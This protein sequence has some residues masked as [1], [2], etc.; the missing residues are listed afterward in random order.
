[1]VWN[2]NS[3]AQLGINIAQDTPG[4][5]FSHRLHDAAKLLG[6]TNQC[7]STHASYVPHPTKVQTTKRK[8]WK[9]WGRKKIRNKKWNKSVVATSAA[10]MGELRPRVS[11]V[12]VIAFRK[13][14]KLSCST[15][16][17]LEKKPIPAL[18]WAKRG[19]ALRALANRT[20]PPPPPDPPVAWLDR[21]KCL[22]DDD[23]VPPNLGHCYH[24][25]R[26]CCCELRCCCCCLS[27]VTI[28]NATA[29]AP[30]LYW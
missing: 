24:H 23:N 14:D 11:R 19:L 25:L 27:H 2:P 30:S 1:M 18:T 17:L 29:D 6:P 4:Y 9:T 13:D 5:I 26:C 22:W 21:Q 15:S 10:S 7:D 28:R 12:I 20:D 16:S 8:Q 3:A